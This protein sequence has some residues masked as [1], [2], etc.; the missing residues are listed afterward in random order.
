MACTVSH[1]VLKFYCRISYRHSDVAKPKINES[2]SFVLLPQEDI[3]LFLVHSE[4]S[5]Y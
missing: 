2:L 5:I 3:Y 1:V 4:V